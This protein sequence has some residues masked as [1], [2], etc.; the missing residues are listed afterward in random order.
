MYK[1]TEIKQAVGKYYKTEFWEL[2]SYS[3]SRRK[4]E[5]VSMGTI[6]LWVDLK[7][8]AGFEYVGF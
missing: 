4:Q 7:G 1:E 8:W 3:A 5:G 2:I 6:H